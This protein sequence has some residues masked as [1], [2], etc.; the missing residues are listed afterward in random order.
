MA[1]SNIIPY[2]FATGRKGDKKS[3]GII[4]ILYKEEIRSG[5]TVAEQIGS[6]VRHLS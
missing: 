2:S 4:M 6:L 1:N 3:S 5:H